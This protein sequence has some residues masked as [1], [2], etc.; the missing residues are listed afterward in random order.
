VLPPF[1]SKP[2]AELAEVDLLRLVDDEVREDVEIDYKVKL[3]TDCQE[4]VKDVSSFANTKGGYLVYGMD[5]EKELPTRLVA[6]EAFDPGNVI[7]RL[8]SWAQ[9][10]IRPRP[11]LRF[12][13]VPLEDGGSVMVV[14]VPRSWV[15][16]HEVRQEHRFYHRTQ[17]GKAPMDVDQLRQAFSQDRDFFQAVEAFHSRRIEH[18]QTRTQGL[19]D[20]CAIFVLHLLPTDGLLGRR[21]FAIGGAPNEARHPFPLPDGLDSSGPEVWRGGSEGGFNLDGYF[22]QESSGVFGERFSCQIFRNGGVEH[23]WV[24]RNEADDRTI[25]SYLFDQWLYRAT[26]Y[27][28]SVIRQVEAL[29]PIA[30]VGSFLG[31]K[32]WGWPLP[33]NPSRPKLIEEPNL[34]LPEVLLDGPDSQ[35]GPAAEQLSNY[36]WNAQGRNRSPNFQN[37]EYKPNG[38][39]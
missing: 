17:H 26:A 7:G 15:G 10:H 4:F 3:E 14:E 13:P 30:M 21:R 6:L 16:P 12:Q 36:L 39:Q 24:S 2:F 37:G 28:L 29:G 31:T 9:E 34:R 18:W 11:I 32:G 23:K 1:P 35:P 25:A 22:F 38:S 20:D 8:N 5:E 19:G 33:A 27:A